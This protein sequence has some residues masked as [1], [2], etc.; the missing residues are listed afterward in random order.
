MTT[1]VDVSLVSESIKIDEIV[2]Q[3]EAPLITKDLTST[4]AIVT[5]DDIKMMPV[6]NIG[7]II[8]L[9]AGVV[10][11]HFRGGRSNEVAYL[12][13]GVPVNDVYNGAN[14]LQ[15]ENNS[16]RELEV[17]SGTFNAEYGKALSGVVNIVTKDGSSF[18]EGFASAYLG[19]YFTN[20]TGIFITLIKLTFLVLK[21]CSLV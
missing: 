20:H 21:I 17:I 4:S 8:N 15:V 11:G 16:V 3:A 9:Q 5:S 7:Q 19:S 13:D 18:Y 12:V 10:D 1:K 6:E 14:A 2:V